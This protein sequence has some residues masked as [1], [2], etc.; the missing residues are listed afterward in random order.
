MFMCFNSTIHFLLLF[1][2]AKRRT[3]ERK[4]FKSKVLDRKNERFHDS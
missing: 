1:G 3:L 4:P 2:D